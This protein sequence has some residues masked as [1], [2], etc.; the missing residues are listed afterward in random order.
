MAVKVRDA[1]VLS[2]ALLG[3]ALTLTLASSG[4]AQGLLPR[5]EPAVLGAWSPAML[6]VALLLACPRRRRTDLVPWAITVSLAAVAG[7]RLL[8]GGPVLEGLAPACLLPMGVQ[9]LSELDR[10]RASLRRP[11]HD[12]F[13]LQLGR[14]RR[15]HRQSPPSA[16]RPHS[17]AS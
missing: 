5:L 10:V 9:A 1:R 6:T 8:I 15:S 2:L 11:R 14:G 17:A 16:A 3:G 4:L 7:R 13:T 12:A